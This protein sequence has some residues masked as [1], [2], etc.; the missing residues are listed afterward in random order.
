MQ[1]RSPTVCRLLVD[2][3]GEGAWNMALDEALLL[4]AERES[5][6]WLRFYQ[7]EQPTL[8]L[9]YFQ[10]YTDRQLHSASADCKLVRRASG[11]GAI[12]HDREL[13]YS[14]ALPASHPLARRAELLYDAAHRSLIETLSNWGID[15][16][17]HVVERPITPG[18][19]DKRSLPASKREEPFL[20]FQRRAPGDILLDS[21]KIAGSAQ[22]RQRGAVLQHG[23]V[24][25]AKSDF[26][27][28]LPGVFELS[29]TSARKEG[30][31]LAAWQ[32]V[33]ARR[34]GFELVPTQIPADVYAGAMAVLA[35]KFGSQG[36]T[37][38]R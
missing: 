14:I 27:P 20:C 38:R 36:W 16:A 2:S 25:L 30:E 12:L 6:A 22:R 31:I 13:T 29:K 28:E 15:A 37:Y 1:A 3:P 5:I 7:W 24:L 26:A 9:G 35:E 18:D 10:N 21:H 33:L 11:G 4:S 23:S 8:S 19:I 32:P 34:L 17:L